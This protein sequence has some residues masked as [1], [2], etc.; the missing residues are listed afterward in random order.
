MTIIIDLKKRR[1]MKRFKL[2]ILLLCVSCVLSAQVSTQNYV[3]SRIILNENGSS[4]MDNISYLDGLGRPFQVVQKAVKNDIRTGSILATLQEYD[5]IGREAKS[6]LPTVI[7]SDYTTPASLKSSAPG[8][9]GNDSRPYSEAI[10]ETSPL[11]RIIK[12][13]EAGAVWYNGHPVKME[14]LANGD[15]LRCINYSVSSTG[16]LTG[17]GNYAANLLNVTKNIDEDGHISFTFVDK[18]GYTL[19]T[20]QM[21]GIEAHDTYYVYDDRSN[22]RFVLQPMYQSLANLDLYA[23]QYKYDGCNRCIWKKQPGSAY[24]EYIY[25]NADR[26]I[27]SQDGKQRASN[28]WTFYG[29]DKLSRLTNQGECTNK[30]P[31]LPD[32][33]FYIQNYYDDYYILSQPGFNNSNF[34]KGATTYGKGHLT[35]SITT[36]LGSGEKIYTAY[37]YDIKGRNT[38]TT[39]SNLLDG[40]DVT[41]TNYTFTSQPGTV[42]HIHTA[43]GKQT[44]TE[45]Y[46]YTYDQ[47]DRVLKVEH[48]LNN[49]KVTL[50]SNTYDDLNRLSTKSLH[51][52][53]SNRLTYTYNI[54]NWLT[55][56]SSSKFK[57]NL[58][59]INGLGNPCYN[60]NISSMTWRT[61]SETSDRGYRFCY[62]NLSRLIDAVY[63][64]GSTLT[65]NMHRFTEKV[66]GY[67]KNGNIKSLQRYGQT[68][69]NS[70]GLIDNLAITLNGNQLRAVNDA[71]ATTAYN[72]GFEFKDG[73]NATS[74]Y[75]YDANGNLTKDL[76]KNI[77]DIQY[78]FLNL[79]DTVTFSDGSTIS[80]LYS[81]DGVKLRTIHKIGST[82]TT[83][84]Y[85]NNVVYENG[86]QKLLLTE[87]GYLSLND[88]K[89]H[90]YLK[91]HQGNNRVVINQ[92]GNVEETN[93]YYPFGGV[94]ASSQ[95]VQP[96][97]Y[98][99]KELDT[100]KGLNWYDY[101]ARQYDA[102]IGRFTT[103]D[104]MTEKYYEWSPYAYCK[105]NPINRIDP[106]GKDDYLLEPRG[107]L[108]NR[109]PKSQRGKSSV[110]RLYSYSGNSRKPM[111]ENIEVKSGL[112]SQM[113]EIQKEEEGYGT[114]GSTQNVKDAAQVFKFAADN[115][116]A[117]WKLDVYNNNG[118]LTAVVATSQKEDNVQ[119]GD[120][121]QKRLSVSGA[122]IVN[123]HSHPNP[124]GTKGGSEQD[125]RNAKPNPTKN[126]VYFK[127]NQTL[128]E[129]DKN[130][131][132]IRETLVQSGIDIL[133]QVGIR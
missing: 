10:Y 27:Y 2:F 39:Q 63:G 90:Y 119:N 98:N 133:K 124:N 104:P 48:T 52:S 68:G 78:N 106:D 122:K 114:Y 88:S 24:V 18:L 115:S 51:G 17:N 65:T 19:L 82:T 55:G 111:G 42:T 45:V 40:Y 123:I 4:Y 125:M 53:A 109:T 110:D 8:N 29:Y 99:G 21:E 43:N 85:C 96:Y 94:F 13:Y 105:N 95:N 54:R 47:A 107:R 80:Y 33:V 61:G 35:G 86:V 67:D 74:E 129:Y 121:A 41:S 116:K 46:T 32:V 73:A 11:H 26:L 93:H 30:N 1:V 81:A 31:S 70:Y 7:S 15:T 62:D 22:L 101:E 89:Y 5:A 92:N 108:H 97:K 87:E 130:Q 120:H 34:S 71:V 79:P 128:Y 118:T 91:D 44:W 131:S 60:G 102:A 50:V 126:A 117:E 75:T 16:V 69:T 20:R 64:E 36:V 57:Q 3:R 23:F 66:T 127:A 113:L 77:T 28:R 84:Y 76:N 58:Y 25:D 59:Y 100:K 38:Q 83:T 49:T 9:Y 112:L 12:Q 37:F 132:K 6:W 14:Y 56:I 72:N 103:M